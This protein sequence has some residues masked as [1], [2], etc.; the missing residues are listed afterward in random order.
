ML[1]KFLEKKYL[2]DE[3]KSFLKLQK[4][5]NLEMY[6][7]FVHLIKTIGSNS[8]LGYLL[9]DLLLMYSETQWNENLVKLLYIS[10]FISDLIKLLKYL[11]KM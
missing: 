1:K 7:C 11:A 4:K 2:T 5:Y 8:L 3:H 10:I 6:N 9:S